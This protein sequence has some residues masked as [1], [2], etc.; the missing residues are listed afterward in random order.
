MKSI[1][2]R[3][4]SYFNNFLNINDQEEDNENTI[5]TAEPFIVEPVELDIQFIIDELKSHKAPGVDG[6]PAELFKSG[7]PS[8]H[9]AVHKLILAIWRQEKLPREWKKSIIIPIH[10][11]G[12]ENNCSNF[13][14]IS[15]LP[16]CYKFLSKILLKRLIIYA[17]EIIGDYQWG[18]QPFRSTMILP[19]A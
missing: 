2:N 15:F 5:H 10:K 7:G 12:G 19:F 3:W 11:K 8:L 9:A 6:I 18:F 16:A 1:L 14:G 4:K 17:K 13:R